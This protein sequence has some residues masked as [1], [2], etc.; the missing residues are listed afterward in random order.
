[1]ALFQTWAIQN[2]TGHIVSVAYRC[3]HQNFESTLTDTT[4]GKPIQTDTYR[5]KTILAKDGPFPASF[6]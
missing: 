4:P 1:M 5:Y 2:D 6:H 3:T